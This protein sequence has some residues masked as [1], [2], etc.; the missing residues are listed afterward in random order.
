MNISSRLVGASRAVVANF[1]FSLLM[2]L[3]A[4]ILVFS[5][6]YPFPYRE[7]SGV[8]KLFLIVFSIN[9]IFGPLLT[10]I[11]F[12]AAKPIAELWRDL[13]L[14]AVIQLVALGYGVWTIAQ[15]RPL[16]LVYEIDRFKVISSLDLLKNA[17][18]VLPSDLQ[19]HWWSGPV[20]VAIREPRNA[21]ERNKVM[22]ESALGGRDFGERPEFYI[23]YEHEQ[24]L[25]ALKRAKPLSDFLKKQ[26]LH[27]KE[28][29]KLLHE[30]NLQL[31]ESVY[32]PVV[33]KQ[34]WTAI[35]NKE[36]QIKDFV[37]GDGF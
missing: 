6:W 27:Q 22:F 9:I 18:S 1:L 15:A 33:S 29:E 5:V 12:N 11:F 13:L 14:V 2:V 7:M 19:P 31:S 8:S 34:N 17:V 30:K 23:A 25:K 35:L 4:G 36:G 20:A 26:P 21:E 32:V 24:A 16:F 3:L 28:V 10:L 37:H